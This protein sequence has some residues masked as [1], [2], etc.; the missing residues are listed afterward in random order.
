[1]IYGAQIGTMMTLQDRVGEIVELVEQ[2]AEA[3]PGLPAWRAW[4]AC[5]YALVGETDKASALLTESA[6]N[7]FDEIFHD[8]VYLS[9]LVRY[10]EAAFQTEHR[11]AASLLYPALE[12]WADVVAWDG[13][14]SAG[15]VRMYLGM[16]AAVLGRHE[17]ADE[18]LRSACEFAERRGM[19]MFA[20]YGR[21]RWAEALA[22]RGES[23]AAQQQAASALE[24]ARK[25]G[26]VLVERRAAALLE[27][28]RV[29]P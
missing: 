11:D 22:R 8:Q 9:T 21:L 3:N 5:T 26:Y 19:P 17:R 28:E 2:G 18:Q 6:R 16:L 25:V 14:S 4:L 20:A 13:A 7:G 1:M 12:P 23:E 24:I 27:S 10:S 15:Q 29:A